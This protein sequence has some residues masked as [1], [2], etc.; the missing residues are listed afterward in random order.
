MRYLQDG[1]PKPSLILLDLVMPVMDGWQ[2][3]AERKGQQE[4][5]QIPVILISGQVNAYD[6]AAS[7]GLAGCID[8]PI[9]I[10][11]LFQTVSQVLAP[12]N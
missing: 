12:R 11:N 1:K 7:Y 8:K 4:L 6:A 5:E 2:F 3:L 9:G 10:A